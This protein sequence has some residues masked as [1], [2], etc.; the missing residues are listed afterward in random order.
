MSPPL[1][2]V[3]EIVVVA[4]AGCLFDIVEYVEGVK[5]D[6]RDPVCALL[7]VVSGDFDGTRVALKTALKQGGAR[8]TSVPN[9][10]SDN[11]RIGGA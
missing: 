1:V 10:A 5:L 2:L 4:G 6:V 7:V 9:R 11:V 8:R 3:T